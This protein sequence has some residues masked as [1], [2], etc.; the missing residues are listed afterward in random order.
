[1]FFHPPLENPRKTTSP[2][3]LAISRGLRRQ[4]KQLWDPASEL[5]GAE[6]QPA[7]CARRAHRMA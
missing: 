3:D 5:V 4:P 2:D 7:R 1:M 6:A